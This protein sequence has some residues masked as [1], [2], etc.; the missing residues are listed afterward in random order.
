MHFLQKR[1]VVRTKEAWQDSM[2]GFL[3]RR[4]F[5]A[6]LCESLRSPLPP[7]PAPV[8]ENRRVNLNDMPKKPKSVISLH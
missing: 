6:L 8:K 2:C 5:C 1:V 3:G 7:T 4:C